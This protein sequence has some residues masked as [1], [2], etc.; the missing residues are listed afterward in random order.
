VS[1]VLNRPRIE[2]Y[3]GGSGSG[4]GVSITRRLQELKPARLLIWDPRDEYGKHAPRFDSLPA[5][6]AAVRTAKG[7]PVRGRYVPGP[8]VDLEEAFGL[9]CQLSFAAGSLLFLAEELSDVTTASRAPAAWR[10][11]IT[12]GRHKALHVLGAAQRPALIDKTFLG[13]ATYIRCFTLRYRN[14]RQAMAAALD[15]PE[16]EIAKLQTVEDDA[17]GVTTINYL[18]RD[19]RAGLL[20]PGRYVLKRRG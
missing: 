10:Q 14:D 4:K 20:Q 15:V 1:G 16:L 11:V 12:Q 18:E 5:L 9:V 19:F 6:V 13:N 17:R 3:I 2:A 8:A 7:G